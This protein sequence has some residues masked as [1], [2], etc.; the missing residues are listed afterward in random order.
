[1]T[2]CCPCSKF[3][4]R[5]SSVSSL[6]CEAASSNLIDIS[7]SQSRR[8]WANFVASSTSTKAV[9]GYI[10]FDIVS[11][12]MP[13]SISSYVAPFCTSG[14][15]SF[16]CFSVSCFISTRLSSHWYRLFV[17]LLPSIVITHGAVHIWK[18]VCVLNI[19]PPLQSTISKQ[20]KSAVS[21][22]SFFAM[23]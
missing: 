11:S 16:G 7:V 22:M 13:S 21:V 4:R 5:S 3:L 2:A 17:S 19:A 14:K 10:R 9:T 12:F 18:P 23:P 1:M 6:A 8:L 15:T 20:P